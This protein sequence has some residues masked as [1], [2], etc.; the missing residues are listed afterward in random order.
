MG[1]EEEMKKSKRKAPRRKVES[2]AEAAEKMERQER[3]AR[4]RNK[5]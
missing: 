1:I 2:L 4:K 3:R 5:N